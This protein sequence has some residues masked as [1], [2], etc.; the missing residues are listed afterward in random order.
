M[1]SPLPLSLRI[2]AGLFILSGISNIIEVFVA[3]MHG[4][5][6]LNF[7]VLNLFVGLG[8]LK[9]SPGW[10]TCGLVFLWLGLIFGPI[11]LIAMLASSGP[12]DFNLFGRKIG[13][14]SKAAVLLI[15][16][17]FYAVLIWQYRVL[18]RA[19]IKAL[20]QGQTIKQAS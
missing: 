10:R 2:V 19:D 17:P 16:I 15:G 4:N 7:G 18:V 12:L 14:A 9:L 6:N 8:L 11:I 1:K 5:V 3:F 13:N 20:F